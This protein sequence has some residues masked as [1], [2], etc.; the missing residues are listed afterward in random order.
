[1]HVLLLLLLLLLLNYCIL[2]QL[3]MNQKNSLVV[4]LVWYFAASAPRPVMRFVQHVVW[5]CR[6]CSS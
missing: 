4:C 6:T 3:E 1:M 5:L 2:A